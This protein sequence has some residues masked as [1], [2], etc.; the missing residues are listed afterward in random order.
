LGSWARA[1]LV[2]SVIEIGYAKRANFRE[3]V[4]TLGALQ[5]SGGIPLSKTA[6]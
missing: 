3:E 4:K 6:K 1:P 2:L 5:Q